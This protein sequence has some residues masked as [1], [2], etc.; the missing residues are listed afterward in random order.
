MIGFLGNLLWQTFWLVYE[1]IERKLFASVTITNSDPVY[2]WVI[3]YLTAQ[4]FLSLSSMADCEV[5]TVEKKSNWWD[6]PS[7]KEKH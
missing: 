6:A 5:K 4:G 1:Y 7:A 2:E 3:K